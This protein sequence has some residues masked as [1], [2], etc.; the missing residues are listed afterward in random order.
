[1]DSPYPQQQVDAADCT[2]CTIVRRGAA[3]SDD[4]LVYRDDEVAAFLDI[5]PLFPGHLLIVPVAHVLTLDQLPADR[6]GPLFGLVQ[7][8][9]AAMATALGADGAFVAN[10]NIVSQSVPHLHVHVVPRRKGD[11]L[12]GFF[13]PRVGYDDDA[14]RRSVQDALRAALTD[15]GTNDATL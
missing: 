13:W 9:V 7:R 3:G 11:G 1:M 15:G 4:G 2:F 5:R 10:N 8:A 6:I 12:R 14:H